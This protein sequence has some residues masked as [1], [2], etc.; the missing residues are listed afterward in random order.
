ME[1]SE[2]YHVKQQFF[3]GA[4]KTLIDLT[5]PDPSSPDYI[6][7]LL[8]QARAHIASDDPSAAISL[9]PEDEENVAVKAVAALARYVAA[10][11]DEDKDTALEALRDL[12]VEIE[13]DDAEGSDKDKALVRVIAGTA[14][15]R[16]GEI[17][18]ALD[19]LGSETEDLEAVAVLV[20]IYLSINRPDLARR[21]FERAKHWAEDDLLLQLIEC[22]IGLATGKDAYANPQSFYTEQLGNPSLSSPHILTA[23]GVTRILRNEFS[24]ARSDLEEAMQQ[25][26]DDAE[27]LAAYTI[28]VSLAPQQKGE[29]DEL[30]VRL[31]SEYPTHPLVTDLAA[32]ASLFDEFAAKFDVPPIAAAA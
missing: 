23:R 11:A 3:L 8:Y 30:F 5:L 26:N 7:T 27:A 32:K 31:Q 18:E 20:H 19:A 1:S 24:A 6:P 29:A 12:L 14:F 28:A 22:N 10:S 16:A 17:E 2:L 9:I 13:G 4:Y 25:K 21:E 15:A